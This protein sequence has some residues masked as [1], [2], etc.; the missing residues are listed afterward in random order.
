MLKKLLIGAAALVLSSCAKDAP[1][2]DETPVTEPAAAETPDFEHN[3]YAD[4]ANWLCH[5][6]K[7]DDA[8]AVDLTATAI[9]A[10]GT[11]S[12][13]PFTPAVEPAFD[14][15]YIYP[16]VSFDP[17]PN[18]DMTPGPEELN[19]VANQFARYG[20]SCRLYA[21]IYR[22]RTLLE[23]RTQMMTGQSTANAEMRYAD[24][25]D[26][27]NNYIKSQNNGRGVVLIGHSQGAGM[28]YD[29]LD[30]DIIG[31][32]DQAKLIAVHAIGFPTTLDPVTGEAAGLPVCKSGSETGCLVNFESFRA[33]NAPPVAS[34][35][36]LADGDRRAVCNNPAALTG[37]GPALNAYMPR[38]SLGRT[39]P[40]DYG[41]TVDTPFVLLP[42]LLTAT[43][44]TN[45]THDWLSIAINADPADPRADDIPGDVVINGEV[46]ADWG[47][48]L[49]D[50]N[51]AMGNLVELAKTEGAAW[52]AAQTPE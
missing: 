41:V 36:G 51:L 27:W 10:D 49:V 47:L 22:Q 33:T 16:T 12:I 48:H 2:V 1:K 15:F 24:V 17:T 4:M 11:T 26:S 18:S 20:E 30:T 34:R 28:I 21:P 32:P 25:I 42:G 45:D 38:Q 46:L 52:Q 6:D 39:E 31:S 44:E 3:D 7:T 9:S 35:F 14:C 50:M 23:L 5:P 43:C 19:V 29:M 8:C 37:N 13:I 40:N